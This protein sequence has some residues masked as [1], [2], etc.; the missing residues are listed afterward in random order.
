MTGYTPIEMMT[1][2]ASRSLAE[3]D[4]CFAGVGPPSEACNLARAVHAPDLVLIYESGAVRARP[5]NLPLSVGDGELCETALCTVSVPEMFCYWLQG[6]HIDI[7]VLSAAQIDRFG[8]IN[9]TIIGDYHAP[10]VRLPGG[11]GAPEIATSCDRIHL[12]V[13]QSRRS[14][15]KELDFRTSFG[16]GEGGLSRSE[17]GILTA[18]PVVL[19]TDLAIWKPDPASKELTVVSLHP[20][21]TRA[22]MHASVDW[23]IKFAE[24]VEITEPPSDEELTV[25]RELHKR[26]KASHFPKKI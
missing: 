5:R 17:A 12:I 3:G 11:G 21:V 24:Q 22:Q 9:T 2:A 7:G 20:G 15:R 8:N 25:L 13:R 6:G 1:V 4:V 10:K 14:F 19:F 26:T 18:G 23:N 16:F